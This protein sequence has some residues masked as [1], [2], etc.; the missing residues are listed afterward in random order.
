MPHDACI[1]TT[2]DF[3]IL[4]VMLDRSSD[5]AEAMTLLLRRKLDAATVVFREDVPPQ[6]ATLSSRVS[7]AV[8]G[9]EADSR[10]LSHDRMTSPVGLYLPITTLRG[11]ALLG[12]AEGQAIRVANRDGVA[13][14]IR[15]DQVLYQPESARRAQEAVELRATPQARR[16]MLRVIPGTLAQQPA[17]ARAHAIDDGDD[18]GPSA[19]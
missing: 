13:E 17:L 14:R 19:A 3:T 4:E 8:D 15:L 7:F 2:K 5:P 16:T 9:G 11:L 10:I 6:V 1:L 18:P 12:L